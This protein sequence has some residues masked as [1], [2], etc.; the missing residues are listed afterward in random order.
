MSDHKADVV[1]IGGG[2][3]GLCTAYFLSQRGASVVVLEKSEIGAGSSWGNAGHIVPSHIV[4]LAAPGVVRQALGWL[5]R[6]D[7]PFKI[8]PRLDFDLVQWL[9]QFK[10]SCS[11]ANVQ[12]AIPVLKALGERSSAL[13]DQMVQQEGLDVGLEARGLLMLYRTA[14]GLAGAVEESHLL[15]Q[16]GIPTAVYDR[17]A[18]VKAEPAVRDDLEGAVHLLGDKHIH[19]G[20]VLRQLSA[21][22]EA[23]GVGLCTHTQ[24]TGLDVRD[25]RVHAVHTSAGTFESTTVVLAAGAWS[26]G[27]ARD[28]KARLPVQPGTGYSITFKRPDGVGPKIPL[29]LGEKRVAVTSMADQLRFTGQLE[30]TQVEPPIQDKKIALIRQA[31]TDYLK[32]LPALETVETWVGMRPTTPDGLPIIGRSARAENLIYATG[33]AMVG[34]SLGP[35]TGEAAAALALGSKP[36]LDL[37][38]VR[39]ARFGC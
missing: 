35:A 22:L 16:H 17:A 4:P 33:H 10:N 30:I 14:E 36:A 19:P 2:I 32:P 29:L 1:V 6:D 15:N 34:L 26:P 18:V 12:R 38:A 24:V 9:W 7:S 23:R 37:H 3:I 28:L 21:K 8:Q 39:P 25:G 20:K 27:I 13:F 11:E 31:V 5:L